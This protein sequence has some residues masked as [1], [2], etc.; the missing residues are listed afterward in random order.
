VLIENDYERFFAFWLA[1]SLK[2]LK[3]M[4]ATFER[5]ANLQP[6]NLQLNLHLYPILR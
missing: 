5:L 6:A 4:I 1:E 3:V 2:V